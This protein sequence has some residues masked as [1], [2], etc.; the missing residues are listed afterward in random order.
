MQIIPLVATP[1]QALTVPLN[2]GSGFQQQSC[3]ISVYQKF[4]GVFLDLTSDGTLIAAGCIAENLN[5]MIRDNSVFI[6]DLLFLDNLGTSDPFYQGLGTRFSLVYLNFSDVTRVNNFL[7]GASSGIN[8]GAG[9]GGRG[10]PTQTDEGGN[11]QPWSAEIVALFNGYRAGALVASSNGDM[12]AFSGGQILTCLFNNNRN[13]P[14]TSPASPDG[15]YG[16]WRS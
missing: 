13:N 2:P 11:I 14:D 12:S 9:G 4:Y 8:Q 1:S 6:G 7:I 5:R 15:S 16:G 10:S 3:A